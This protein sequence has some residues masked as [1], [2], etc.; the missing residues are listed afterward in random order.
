MLSQADNDGIWGVMHAYI[1][2]SSAC[3]RDDRCLTGKA[4]LRKLTLVARVSPTFTAFS[5]RS[6]LFLDGWAVSK[7]GSKFH[8][9]TIRETP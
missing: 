7:L 1:R 4:G 8:L 2:D 5:S 3:L 9:G 6:D